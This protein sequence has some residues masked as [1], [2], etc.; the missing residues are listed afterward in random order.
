MKTVSIILPCYQEQDSLPL[1]FKAADE[2]LKGLR[3]KYDFNFILIN[4]GSKDK[5]LEVMEKLYEERDDITVLSLSRNFGQNPALTAGL[6]EADSDFVITMDVDLQDPVN[7]IPDILHALDEEGYDVVNPHRASR[8]KDTFIKRTTAKMFYS[9]LNK[10][11][12]RKV[13]PENVNLYR[14]FSR[15][16]YKEVL[17]LPEKDRYL[18]NEVPFVGY[19]IKQ[20]DY[21]RG[22]RSA[23]ETKYSLK[24]LFDVAFSVLSTGTSRPLFLPMVFSVFLFGFFFLAFL[25]FLVFFLLGNLGIGPFLLSWVTPCFILTG[26]LSGLSLFSFFFGIYGLY[27]HNILLNTRERPTYILDFKKEK[28]KKK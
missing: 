6:E 7:L 18:I 21:A 4:D 9:F 20:I 28:G 10:I 26:V 25:T 13:I 15:R 14:G 23:D 16:A 2:A 12:G 3:D 8:K 5:T 22:E 1:Y 19:K 27:L 17:A 11:E 24:K